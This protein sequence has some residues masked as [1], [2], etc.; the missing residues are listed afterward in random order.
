MYG[1]AALVTGGSRGI[2]KAIAEVFR[3]NGCRV[4]TP[5]REQLD[6]SDPQSITAYAL[7]QPSP[8]DIIVNNAGINHIVNLDRLTPEQL[9]ETLQINLAAPVHLTRALIAGMKSRRYGRIVNL[10]S[11]WS[12]VSKEGRGA[13]SAAKSAINGI[14]RTMAIEFG[15]YNILVNAVAPGYVNTDLTRQ[16]NSAEQID[17]IRSTI[18]LNRLAQPREIAE[19]I[20]FLCSEK[21]SYITGQTIAV[22]GGFLCR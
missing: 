18:P 12:L 6:L 2:G 22:D 9:L 11:I 10:S 3:E 13:Y 14:T 20:M 1:K 19:T 17:S 4:E 21:N 15:P 5:G 7:R 8:F 16:N